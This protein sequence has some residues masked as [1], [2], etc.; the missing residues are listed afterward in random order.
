M[1]DDSDGAIDILVL[2]AQ[3]NAITT[4]KRHN[5]KT[6]KDDFGTSQPF[7]YKIVFFNIIS[8]T[9]RHENRECTKISRNTSDLLSL[10]YNRTV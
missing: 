8:T 6:S 5:Q 2:Y 1:R 3:C 10:F 4:K 7:D 9:D